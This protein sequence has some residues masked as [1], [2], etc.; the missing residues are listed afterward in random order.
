M[1][2]KLKLKVIKS[3]IEDLSLQCQIWYFSKPCREVTTN[4]RISEKVWA[5]LVCSHEASN[6]WKFAGKLL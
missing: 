6:F 5:V 2:E 4:L 3:H 1:P